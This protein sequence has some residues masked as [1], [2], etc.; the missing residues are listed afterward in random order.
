[1]RNRRPPA[2]EAL[3][4][5]EPEGP[6]GPSDRRAARRGVRHPDRAVP[7]QRHGEADR[8]P[9]PLFGH[10]AGIMGEIGYGKDEIDEFEKTGPF[11]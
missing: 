10:P 1:M 3:H 4:D 11:S 9:H 8:P 5:A 7:P 2:G 6:A